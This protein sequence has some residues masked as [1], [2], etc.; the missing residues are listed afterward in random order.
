MGF[1]R[2]EWYQTDYWRI[3]TSAGTC[4]VPKDVESDRSRLAPYV[5]VGTY[6]PDDDVYAESG[7]VGRMSAPG[8]MDCTDW[9]ACETEEEVKRELAEAYDLNPETM[10]EGEEG[11]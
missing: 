4:I 9:I 5:D 6:D 2:A 3:E 11:T 10:Q 8:Y 1:M 7:W